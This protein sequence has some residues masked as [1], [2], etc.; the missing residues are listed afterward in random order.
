MFSRYLIVCF[1]FVLYS[2]IGHPIA[3]GRDWYVDNVAGD[4]LWNGTEAAPGAPLGPT[5]TIAKAL[6]MAGAGDRIVLANSGRPY[7]ESISL[8]GNRHSGRVDRPFIIEGNGATLSGSAP[9]PDRW[10]AVQNN[11]F[12]FPL[13]QL[14]YQQLFLDGL[15]ARQLATT[16]RMSTV[17][18]LQPLEWILSKGHLYFRVEKDRLPHQYNPSFASQPTGITLYKVR[19]AVVVD[20]FVQ[21]FQI[22]GVQVHDSVGPVLLSGLTCRGNGRSGIAIRG[23]SQAAID[24]CLVGDNGR[25]Q[26]FMDGPSE[27]RITN[28]ELLDKV[29]PKWQ[30][31]SSRLFV[32]GARIE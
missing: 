11:T 18:E 17:N 16:S 1:A 2:A 12:R 22:D 13:Q 7:Q 24:D 25:S 28:S 29:A 30:I 15:P 6:R 14:Q 10:E 32:D 21:G 31:N 5:Q 27:A 19:N 9:V 20:L 23:A 26:I 3:I 4:D 8:V